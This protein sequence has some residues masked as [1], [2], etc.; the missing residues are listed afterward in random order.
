MILVLK[1]Q[2]MA[3]TDPFATHQNILVDLR[4]GFF[5][6][7]GFF[8]INPLD[9]GDFQAFS[10]RDSI[11]EIENNPIGGWYWSVLDPAIY[12]S[13]NLQ[14]VTQMRLRFAL[15]DNDDLGEDLISFYSGNYDQQGERPRLLVEFY[16][17][18]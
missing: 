11:G 6:S 10:D 7:A 15:D 16:L 12:P 5:G 3:G 8:G 13:I 9:E 14:G 2:G 18:Q 17:R 1:L 4:C